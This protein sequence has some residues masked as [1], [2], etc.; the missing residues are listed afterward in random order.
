MANLNLDGIA[1]AD[2]VVETIVSI[3]LQDIEGVS[4]VGAP[5]PAALIGSLAQARPAPQGVEVTV[6]D[7]NAL[8][9]AVHTEA[10]F[11][12][13]LP[14]LAAKVRSAVSDAILAQVGVEVA[15][16]DVYIDQ[17]QF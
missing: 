6:V 2:G 15:S 16:V 7:G 4:L 13:T 5:G 8:S 1:I 17:V 9:V 11:G 12:Y 14:D 10:K 3:A